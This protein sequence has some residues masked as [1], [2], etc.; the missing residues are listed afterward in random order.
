MSSA[1]CL[2][3][4]TGGLLRLALAVAIVVGLATAVA[5]VGLRAAGVEPR[6]PAEQANTVP[7]GWTGFRLR[8]GVTGEEPLVTNDLGMHAP[9]SYTLQRPPGV[10]RVAVLGSSVV[11]GLGM[12]FA[13]TIP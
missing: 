2:C 1:A 9:R 7:D 12:S 5:E 10:V 6:P 11:Y 13:D 8:P 4:M 3:T